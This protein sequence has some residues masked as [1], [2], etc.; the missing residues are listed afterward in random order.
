MKHFYEIGAPSHMLTVRSDREHFFNKH[1]TNS[2][3]LFLM[4]CKI[5][6]VDKLQFLYEPVR[7]ESL[8]VTSYLVNGVPVSLG[9]EWCHRWT[10]PGERQECYSLLI[11]AKDCGPGAVYVCFWT[12]G[13]KRLWRGDRV[14]AYVHVWRLCC[15]TAMWRL[16][17]V[18]S[19][20]ERGSVW[21]FTANSQS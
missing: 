8:R 13:M 5:F 1:L 19:S 14:Y 11:E 10:A 17:S 4:S 7:E 18:Q 20:C 16:V 9:I 12:C 3:C 15:N 21:I 6:Y 2:F